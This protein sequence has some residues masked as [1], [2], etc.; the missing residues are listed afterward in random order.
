[1]FARRHLHQNRLNSSFK[2]PKKQDLHTLKSSLISAVIRLTLTEQPLLANTIKPSISPPQS[3]SFQT[4]HLCHHSVQKQVLDYTVLGW[5]GRSFL[6]PYNEVRNKF[7]I[8]FRFWKVHRSHYCSMISSRN[9]WVGFRP[10]FFF[11][12]F[13]KSNTVNAQHSQEN[14]KSFSMRSLK[15]KGIPLH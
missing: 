1:M 9:V 15:T 12:F 8:R 6:S 4:I 13:H 3:P 10:F 14:K 7:S 2:Y 5:T 11:F